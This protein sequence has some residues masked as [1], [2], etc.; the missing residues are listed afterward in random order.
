MAAYANLHL[1]FEQMRVRARRAERRDAAEQDGTGPDNAIGLIQQGGGGGGGGG[2]GGG[3][4]ASGGDD[5]EDEEPPRVL[6]VG[7]EH[8]G[9]TTA[10]KLLV[11]YAVRGTAA[12]SPLYVNLDPSDGGFTI[13]GTV[14][15]CVIDSPLPTSSPAN[16]LGITATSAPTA[17]SSSKLTPLVHWYGHT[18][19]K[20]NAG[21]M[22]H[23]IRVLN[24][25]CQERLEIDALARTSGIIIDTPANFTAVPM[26]DKFA[27][28][29]AAVYAFRVNVI[30]VIGNEKLTVEMQKIF[31]SEEAKGQSQRPIT[32][33]KIPRSPG[34]VDLDSAYCERVQ[35]HQVKNYFYGSPLQLPPEL[36][37]AFTSAGGREGQGL[38]GLNLGGEAAAMDLA[39]SPH[40]SVVSFDDLTIYRIG[41]DSFAPSSALP[42]GASRAL[43]EMQP[44]KIDPSQPGQG[45]VNIVLAVLSLTEAPEMDIEEA[46]LDADVLGFVVIT[47]IDTENNRFTVLVPSAASL[48]GRVALTGSIQWQEA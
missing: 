7:P 19:V 29:K 16:P 26:Q 44:V 43:G 9:K 8:S 13:P 5:D 2:S 47:S 6:I 18:D 34:V 37:A 21:L 46:I 17:L 1:A 35:A 31:S 3:S 12:C 15:A 39:L 11:N 33:L 41:Q 4:G 14:S 24:E 48:A 36:A 27:L 20:K 38:S 32:V 45:I 10:C 42:I 28:V 25:E 23:L 22:E 40:S 30:L